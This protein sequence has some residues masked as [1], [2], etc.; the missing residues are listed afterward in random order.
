MAERP[1]LRMLGQKNPEAEETLA[2]SLRA[3]HAHTRMEILAIYQAFGYTTSAIDPLKQPK[4]FEHRTK[5]PLHLTVH[6]GLNIYYD[7][8][9][10]P[11][12]TDILKVQKMIDK[13]IRQKELK[14]EFDRASREALPG[15]K[16][17]EMHNRWNRLVSRF[18]SGEIGLATFSQ[19]TRFKDPGELLVET[20][21]ELRWVM[22]ELGLAQDAIDR[23][24]E[25][26]LK[27]WKIALQC[28][29]RARM[30]VRLVRNN[31]RPGWIRQAITSLE[32]PD[33]FTD[34]MARLA[35]R[36]ATGAPG[37][38]MSPSDQLALQRIDVRKS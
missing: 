9:L 19:L 30:G 1:K 22:R 25:H 17:D 38:K 21:E 23:D 31:A 27:H 37:E 28:N 33:W 34:D 13:M 15:A 14:R 11:R 20:E 6:R 4:R 36:R 29:L 24:V 32:I 26:E 5:I 2:G 35:L 18:L 8:R 12:K 16:S 3:G 7:G 10:Q